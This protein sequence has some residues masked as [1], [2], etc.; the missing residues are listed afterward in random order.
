MPTLHF[1]RAVFSCMAME[2]SA[3]MASTE[4]RTLK[5]KTSFQEVLDWGVPQETIE[6]ILGSPMPNPLTKVKDH[7]LELGL[8]FEEIKPVIQGEI[9]KVAP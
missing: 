4:D 5:G 6:S 8:S 1:T 9:D 7:C 2:A 3:E